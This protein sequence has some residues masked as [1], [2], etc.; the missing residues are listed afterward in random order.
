MFENLPLLS[1]T[2]WA[3]LLGGVW[4]LY[5]G[6]RQEG[7]VKVFTLIVSLIVFFLT[8]V[9]YAGFDNGTYAM[10]F[11]E[12]SVWIKAFNINYHLGIDGIS[13]P[14]IILTSSIHSSF[15]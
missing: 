9:L 7:T 14:L 6:D 11:V 1:L 15:R 4:V 10:Q 8:L 5:A 3:P 12:K 13:L 2:I